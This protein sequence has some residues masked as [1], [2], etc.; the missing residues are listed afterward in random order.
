[1]SSIN[2]NTTLRVPQKVMKVRLYPKRA[3]HGAIN[4]DTMPTNGTRDSIKPICAESKF[5]S[6][7]NSTK[8]EPLKVS[9]KKP[10]F[11]E[12]PATSHGSRRI[13]S[14]SVRGADCVFMGKSYLRM[15]K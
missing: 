6:L 11:S 10:V 3:T 12:S 9:R 5:N 15:N 4:G 13:F 1:M 14:T 2:A 8:T 7:R